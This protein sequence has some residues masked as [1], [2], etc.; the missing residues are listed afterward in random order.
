MGHSE[1]GVPCRA[2]QIA[3]SD[4]RTKR[5]VG[6]M[7]KVAMSISAVLVLFVC[8]AALAGATW[9]GGGG[10]DANW[11]TAAN[12]D[13]DTLPLFDGTEDIVFGVTAWNGATT[14]LDG[15]KHIYS[16]T[17]EDLSM[18]AVVIAGDTLILESGNLTKTMYIAL[19]IDSNVQLNATGVWNVAREGASS[20]VTTVNGA[21]TEGGS[22]S[23]LNVTGDKELV[24]AGA[25]TFDG[26]LVLN[27]EAALEV[28]ISGD[29]SARDGDTIVHEGQLILNHANALGT[30]KLIIDS[31]V[32]NDYADLGS[33][34]SGELTVAND[35][36][37]AGPQLGFHIESGTS[38]IMAGA[39][40]QLTQDFTFRD[41]GGGG[42]LI[43]EGDVTDGGAG[44]GITR[45]GSAGT[46]ELRGNNAIGGDVTVT[47][48]KLV[49]HGDNAFSGDVSVSGGELVLTGDYAFSGDVTV[50]GGSLG[51]SGDNVFSRD[52][53]VTNGGLGLYG[54][55]SASAV[56]VIL[57][58]GTLHLG[59]LAGL[60][61]GKLIVRGGGLRYDGA[62]SHAGGIEIEGEV[63]L[64]V[65]LQGAV[66][67]GDLTVSMMSSS[68]PLA[69]LSDITDGGGGY[70]IRVAHAGGGL[71][72]AALMG[73]N[74]FGGDIILEDTTYFY[75]TDADNSACT[76]D[77]RVTGGTDLQLHADAMPQ[78]KLVLGAPGGSLIRRLNVR[79]TFTNAAELAGQIELLNGN[80][81]PFILAGPVTLIG[82]TEITSWTRGIYIV[83]HFALGYVDISGDISDG[84]NGYGL[85]LRRGY[86]MADLVVT[87]SGDNTFSGGVTV[88]QPVMDLDLDFDLYVGSA[89]AFGTGGLTIADYVSITGLGGPV[90]VASA[91][92]INS[93]VHLTDIGFSGAAQ[94]DAD[95]A[96]NADGWVAL[97]GGVGAPPGTTL[98][99]TGGGFLGGGGTW[100]VNV[101][102]QDGEFGGDGTINGTLTASGGTINPGNSTGIL[103]V[104]GDVVL[105]PGGGL[106]V[107][108]DGSL[109]GE[110]NVL[111]VNGT[112]TLGD[113]EGQPTLDAYLSDRDI[114]S[115]ALLTILDNDGA[116]GIV[117]LFSGLGE[118]ATVSLI[119]NDRYHQISSASA[120]ISYVG[121][122]GNDITLSN[123][124][125]TV[126]ILPGDMDGSGAVNNNDISPFVLAMTDRAQ[127]E[128]NYPGLD[129]DEVGDIDG[130]GA[131]NNNDLTPFVILLTSGSYPQAVPEPA[132]L[133]LLALGAAGLLR[134]RRK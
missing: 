75:M 4:S 125:V 6:T 60:P 117:G 108:I 45:A 88:G 73:T 37:A 3:R 118:G 101:D 10:A 57:D 132:T 71:F 89:T 42:T 126:V 85:L 44:F 86:D 67:T 21:I 69:V 59:S 77:L 14:T 62:L 96:I 81:D 93:D 87:L 90:T 65:N 124:A 134:S 43:V 63:S 52:V 12:W 47:G 54:D 107:E 34:F 32:D 129:A 58:N 68:M 22:T 31:P 131:L 122:D 24:L 80:S 55:N 82:D 130:S 18:F 27:G 123:F 30:G 72:G 1:T 119:P 102:V 78:G 113:G 95:H 61:S 84:G 35:W 104:N 103:T 46:V 114:A 13:G 17:A 100:N 49:L 128:I 41:T 56:D 36:A 115:S 23:G 20:R 33:S 9:D 48:G 127:Y 133:A 110:Y 106:K 121:G 50:T 25:N 5:E 2:G 38:L 92:Q 39:F 74:A 26:D 105:A 120:T 94:L 7:K 109:A 11:T 79:G 15:D 53:T 99:K 112:V 16:L 76:G 29:N 64:W 51:L 116:E 83:V 111:A 98:T 70:G 40:D 8:P 28:T 19:T 97:S 66:L 91:V